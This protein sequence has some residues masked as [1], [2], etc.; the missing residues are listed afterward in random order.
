MFYF[1]IRNTA[2]LKTLRG[3][4]D[5]RGV[6]STKRDNER[7]VFQD[8]KF[9]EVKSIFGCV[10]AIFPFASLVNIPSPQV[11]FCLPQVGSDMKWLG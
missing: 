10:S 1:F 9:D 8:F 5:R 3:L 7:G 4:Q 6:R 11:L 2:L